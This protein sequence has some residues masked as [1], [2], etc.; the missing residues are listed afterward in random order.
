MNRHRDSS[1][2]FHERGRE[3]RMESLDGEGGTEGKGGESK[4]G[5]CWFF[6]TKFHWIRQKA[7]VTMIHRSF[8]ADKMVAMVMVIRTCLSK[9]TVCMHVCV[10]VCTME[11]RLCE[12]N[13]S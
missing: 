6:W 5:G 12:G 7:P 1:K 13:F 8:G 3:E 2:I 4:V 9:S 10:C 11:L